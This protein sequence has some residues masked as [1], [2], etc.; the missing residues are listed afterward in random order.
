MASKAKSAQGSKVFRGDG[1]TPEVFTQIAAVTGFKGPDA[2]ATTIDITDMDSEAMEFVPGLP[3]NG[4]VSIDFNFVG[5]DLQQQ[6]LAADIAA[7]N[8]RNHRLVVNDHKTRPSTFDFFGLVT[9]H[10]I[11]GGTNQA[12]KGSASIKISG[13]VTPVYRPSTS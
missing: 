2:K 11:S 5:S 12:L 9:D 8:M 4:S 7:G 13:K 1:N 6:G 3:D 10:G